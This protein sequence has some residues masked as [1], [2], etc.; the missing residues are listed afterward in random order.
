MKNQFSFSSQFS[1]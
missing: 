1:H